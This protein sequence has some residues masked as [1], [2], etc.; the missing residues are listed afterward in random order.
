MSAPFGNSKIKTIAI[1]VLIL[2]PMLLAI[3][4]TAW[5]VYA[6]VQSVRTEVLGDQMRRLRRELGRR[7]GRIERYFETADV[8][9]S[10][11]G[12]PWPDSST[13]KKEVL[14]NWTPAITAGEDYW[15][16]VNRHGV[17]ILH[18]DPSFIGK[19]L[20]SEWDDERERAVG[21]DVVRTQSPALSGEVDA[22][23]VYTPLAMGDERIGM[24]HSGVFATSVDQRIAEAQ[25]TFLLG[26]LAVITP[27]LLTTIGAGFGLYFLSRRLAS[28]QGK[29]ESQRA[30]E[31]QRLARLGI[32]LAHEVRNPLH[33]LRLNIHTLR[34]T[35]TTKTLSEQEMNDMM[36]ESCDEIDRLESLMRSLVQYAAPQ[37]SDPPTEIEIDREARAYLDL[38]GEELRRRRIEV[39][40]TPVKSP[41]VVRM[42]LSRYRSILHELFGFAQRSA[43]EGG[44]IEVEIHANAKM[45]EIA[46][47]DGGRDL[48]PQD[49]ARLFEP[50]QSTPFSEA[51]LGLALIHQYV[52]EC[53]GTLTRRQSPGA[54]RFELRLPLAKPAA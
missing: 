30:E 17:V 15:A 5:D 19:R 3:G 18:S 54:N 39:D 45:A 46:I 1:F 8:D 28:L 4:G 7:A 21:D 35:L 51:G 31:A 22:Y 20:T 40:F 13:E 36:R 47:R 2:A 9:W 26:R 23:N 41:V 53:G 34:R 27:L 25:R 33:A 16:I 24:L 12:A 52:A 43:G 6:D 37:P 44:R 48:S 49:L 42:P 10:L 32:G 29:I 38:L 50:F 11:H 14:G